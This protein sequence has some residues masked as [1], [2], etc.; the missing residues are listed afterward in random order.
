MLEAVISVSMCRRRTPVKSISYDRTS[1]ELKDGIVW[2]SRWI[3]LTET[4]DKNLVYAKYHDARLRDVTLCHRGPEHA[5]D[6]RVEWIKVNLFGGVLGNFI[7]MADHGF[8]M[9]N[10]V[11]ARR[12]KGSGLTGFELREV[13]ELAENSSGIEAPRFLLFAITG[14]G[15]FCH[16]FKVQG[17][18]NLCPK[19]R[20]SAVIC[21]VLRDNLRELPILQVQARGV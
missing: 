9:V 11:F 21:G 16:R 15:G 4:L 19:C 7:Q 3:S 12:L 13:V 20:R 18:S 6:V 17:D 1:G 8:L 2:E 5:T 14:K 10:E